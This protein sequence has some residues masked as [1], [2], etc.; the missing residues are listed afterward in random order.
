MMVEGQKY[1][2][3]ENPGE[4]VYLAGLINSAL[5]CTWARGA[6]VVNAV[7]ESVYFMIDRPYLYVYQDS[8]LKRIDFII[9]EFIKNMV[10]GAQIYKAVNSGRC[11]KC[12]VFSSMSSRAITILF[13]NSGRID[14]EAFITMCDEIVGEQEK[15]LWYELERFRE[16]LLAFVFDTTDKTRFKWVSE[17]KTEHAQRIANRP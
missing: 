13:Q 7:D 8:V 17:L 16:G 11:S 6:G 14:E 9:T 15:M 5:R 2:G 12:R 10:E 3:R 1:H 4:K